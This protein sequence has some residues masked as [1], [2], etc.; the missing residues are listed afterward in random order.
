MRISNLLKA[1]I[2]AGV[3]CLASFPSVLA[4]DEALPESEVMMQALADELER[5]M[6]LQL[7]DLDKPYFIQFM[8]DD[9]LGFMISAEY[10]VITGFERDRSRRFSDQVRVGSY[11]LDNT[12]YSGGRGGF[13]FSRRRGGGGRSGGRASLPI[14]DDY[15]AIRQA[16]WWAVDSS[17]K[18]AVETLTQKRAYMKDKKMDD[19]PNDFTKATAAEHMEAPVRITFDEDA[20]KAKLKKISN[21]FRKYPKIQGSGLELIVGASHQYI[22][23]SEGTRLRTSRTGAMLLVDA[24]VQAKDGMILTDQISFYAKTVD[25]LPAIEEILAKTDE[26]VNNLTSAMQAP[27][28]ES[29][30]G[31]ILFDGLASNQVFQELLVP[32]LAGRVEPVGSRRSRRSQGTL[33]NKIGRQVLPD[34]FQVYDD[35]SMAD[36]NGKPLLGHYT[37]D[38]EGIPASKVSIVEDGDLQ[39]LLMSRTPTKK[40]T[41]SNGHARRGSGSGRINA[42]IANLVI[43][44]SSGLGDAELKSELIAAADDQGLDFGIMIRKIASNSMPNFSS[45]RSMMN[46]IM[47]MQR[48]GGEGPT[49]GDPILVYKV[50]VEDGREELVR[51]CEFGQVKVRD[52][53]DIIAASSTMKVHNQAGMGRSST[54]SSIVAPS[55]LFEELELNPIEAEHSKPPLLGS[56]FFR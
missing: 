19:R 42:G 53:K 21:Q 18:S 15:T 56:P 33:E 47:N 20:W 29:Y 34:T 27:I 1:M 37:Y 12:N 39:T 13:S 49:L 10:G 55:I 3:F 25:E 8:V 48:G 43:Q 24:E 7:E 44:D 52:L 50:F 46:F 31:P 16:I 5:S 26:L 35:P 22:V 14:D 54:T 11:E 6:E 40:L 36:W 51:G 45:Q 4:V 23:N 2:L 38:A 17:Y 41:G 28:L 30:T 9:S 32:Q